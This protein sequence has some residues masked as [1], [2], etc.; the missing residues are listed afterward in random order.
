MWS[1][2]ATAF[3]V[4]DVFAEPATPGPT[5]PALG[6][7]ILWLGLAYG[8]AD[9]ILLSAFPLLVATALFRGRLAGLARRAGFVVAVL[10]LS[11]IITAT[12]HAGYAQYRAHGLARNGLGGPLVGNTII[13]LPAALSAN[14]LG[15]LAAH[16]AMHVAAVVR[17]Y[18]TD[19]FLPPRTPASSPR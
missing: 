11:L 2:L 4:R 10:G 17:A 19:V 8:V 5:G 18:E 1:V 3:V 12:Y 7:A 14:P 15:S 6:L 16:A 13:T 9:A